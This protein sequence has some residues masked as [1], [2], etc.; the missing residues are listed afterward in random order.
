MNL[1]YLINKYKLNFSINSKLLKELEAVKFD[2]TN[3]YKYHSK[4]III[5]NHYLEDDIGDYLYQ[6]IRNNLKIRNSYTYGKRR[7]NIFSEHKLPINYIK[8]ID[9]ILNF[10][11]GAIGRPKTYLIDIYLLDEPKKIS[12]RFPNLNKDVVNGG[13]NLIEKRKVVIYR[14]EEWEKVLVH[15]LI[16]YLNW[17]I[18]T[19]LKSLL[20]AFK[21][22]NS[23][24]YISP[25][26]GYTE[27][28]ALIL[29]YFIK[30]KDIN[31]CMTRELAWGFVQSAKFLKYKNLDNYQDL[32]S[33]K[34]YTQDSFLLGYFVLKTYFLFKKRYQKCIKLG[35]N[36]D[37][38]CFKDINLRDKKFSA[39]INY[40]LENLNE[41]DK[42]FKMSLTN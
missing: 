15:E 36:D 18:Y 37:V 24:S 5:N 28:F 21:D 39:I 2:Q 6:K 34:R 26:E 25:N 3:F 23:D 40:C 31:E 4:K 7:I 11:D 41:R 27:F 14:K 8:K 30:N 9:R 13:S 29:Y 10:F 19:I 35:E 16:H 1:N 22:I 12:S 42:S 33:G 38:D 20:Y 32:F 17:H